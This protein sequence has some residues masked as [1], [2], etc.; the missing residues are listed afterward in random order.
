[1]KGEPAKALK[2]EEQ[3]GKDLVTNKEVKERV[4]YDAKPDESQEAVVEETNEQNTD[5]LGTEASQ[6]E[7]STEKT[8]EKKDIDELAVLKETV[9]KL[10]AE[11]SK[12][13]DSMQKRID[14]LTWKVKNNEEKQER[15]KDRTWDDIT[16]PEEIKQYISHY[17]NEG[18]GNM[19]AFLTDK[20]TDVKIN[21]SLTSEKNAANNNAIRANTWAETVDQFPDLKDPNSEHYQKTLAL[22]QKDPRYDDINK[23]PEGHAVAARMVAVEI[24]QAKLKAD[25]M[26]SKEAE[27]T[28]KKEVAQNSLDVSGGKISNSSGKNDVASMM[29]K[30]MDS[31]DPYGPEWR[32]VLRKINSK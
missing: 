21:K 17:T 26:K 1:M 18:N 13:K 22:I 32:E 9:D 25:G 3:M 10:T 11:N 4:A 24:L 30:A 29:D 19:V 6:S 2:Q 16:D 28:A 5:A 7:S 14:E 31:K 20:L 8:S 15:S 12:V 23:I 27:A